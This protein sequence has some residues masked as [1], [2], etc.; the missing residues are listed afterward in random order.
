MIDLKVSNFASLPSTKIIFYTAIM[1]SKSAASQLATSEQQMQNILQYIEE[2]VDLVENVPNEIIRQITQLHEQNHIYNQLS[3]KLEQSMKLLF[4]DEEL[5]FDNLETEQTANKSTKE[6]PKASS[7]KSTVKNGDVNSKSNASDVDKSKTEKLSKTNRQVT[8]EMQ[9]KAMYVVQKCLLEMQEIS[10]EKLQ[11]VQSILDQLDLKSRA[12]DGNFRSIS[13]SGS[14]AVGLSS[15]KSNNVE[16]SNS[17]D[18]NVQSNAD[19]H[20]KTEAGNSNDADNGHNGTSGNSK[21]ASSRRN[22]SGGKHEDANGNGTT[23]ANNSNKRGV[24]RGVKGAN[25]KESLKRNKGGS[26]NQTKDVLNNSPNT[27]YDEPPI[28][29]DEP[30]YC[31]CEQVSFGEMICCDNSS[32]QIEWF[33]FSCVAL[34]TKPKGKWYC[35][36]CR[37]DRSNIP[38]K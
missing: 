16:T 34:S 24:K 14:L 8:E 28:D 29:P 10:D 15:S 20:I 21:R 11:I 23:G 30:T 22:F 26:N 37:G 25:A 19:D 35:P 7:V 33:H 1:A 6:T 31:L 9:I 17:R 38:K 36:N 12:L 4:G 18:A 3:A 5:D 13:A 32:C 2:Y 27:L